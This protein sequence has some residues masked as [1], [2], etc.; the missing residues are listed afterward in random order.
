MLSFCVMG[1]SGTEELDGLLGKMDVSLLHLHI[2][3]FSL[4]LRAVLSLLLEG[5]LPL[6][7]DNVDNV[8]TSVYL[9]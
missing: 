4:T 2:F 5:H 9:R 6:T 3:L 8:N 1:R 7:A